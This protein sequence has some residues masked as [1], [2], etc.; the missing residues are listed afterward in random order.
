M[1]HMVLRCASS[2]ATILN[3]MDLAQR[4]LTPDFDFLHFSGG[5]MD[6]VSYGIC[7]YDTIYFWILCLCIDSSTTRRGRRREKSRNHVHARL[8]GETFERW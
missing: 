2:K 1:D 5:G 8:L 3:S 6:C 4:S 7:A